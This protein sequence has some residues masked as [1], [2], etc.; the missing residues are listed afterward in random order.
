MRERP[1]RLA[2]GKGRCDRHEFHLPCFVVRRSVHNRAVPLESSMK[3]PRLWTRVY[4]RLQ[5]RTHTDMCIYIQARSSLSHAVVEAREGSDALVRAAGWRVAVSGVARGRKGRGRPEVAGGSRGAKERT[6][7]PSVLPVES[8]TQNGS[9]SPPF[10][11]RPAGIPTSA[12]VHGR[13]MPRPLLYRGCALTLCAGRASSCAL[14]LFLP[15]F[16]LPPLPH[17]FLFFFCRSRLPCSF[18]SLLTDF[19]ARL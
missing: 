19:P 11:I 16:P 15:L 8:E 5:R 10:R 1:S 7:P 12:K 6:K 18:S 13:A 14:L 2:S 9:L 17:L 3:D 4:T